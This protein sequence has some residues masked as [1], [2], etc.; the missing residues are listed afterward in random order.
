M[1]LNFLDIRDPNMRD[2]PFLPVKK[3]K[4]KGIRKS[5]TNKIIGHYFN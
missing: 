2:K 5:P 4:K 1:D 3:R